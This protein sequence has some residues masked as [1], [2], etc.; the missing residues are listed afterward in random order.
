VIDSSGSR[1]VKTP[2]LGIFLQAHP[3]RSNPFA[4]VGELVK[5]GQCLGLLQVGSLLM[6]V[7]APCD[8]VMETYTLASG[9]TV[10]YGTP[11][12]TLQTI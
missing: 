4:Q 12:L 7:P 1:V 8:G 10:G 3:M 5:Q 6:P 9:S 2:G 11:V